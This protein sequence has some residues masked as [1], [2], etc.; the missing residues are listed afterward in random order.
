M[1]VVLGVL[2]LSCFVVCAVVA[3]L[4]ARVERE[5]RRRLQ[6]L[7]DGSSDEVPLDARRAGGSVR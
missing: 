1:R 6:E 5:T 7:M 3:L 2:I 4:D